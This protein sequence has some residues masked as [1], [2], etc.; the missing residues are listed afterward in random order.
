MFDGQDGMS[1]YVYSSGQWIST[2]KTVNSV[3]AQTQ[4]SATL[5]NLFMNITIL[6]LRW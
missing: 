2:L 3:I 1:F 4:L 6:L 5:Q